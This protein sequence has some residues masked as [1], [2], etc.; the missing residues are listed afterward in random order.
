MTPNQTYVLLSKEDIDTNPHVTQS[1]KHAHT[2]YFE[3]IV[4]EFG[5]KSRYG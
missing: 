5:Y 1:R 2:T 4:S 3:R